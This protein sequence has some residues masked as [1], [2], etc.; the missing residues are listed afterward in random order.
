[1]DIQKL[2]LNNTKERYKLELE[3]TDNEDAKQQIINIINKLDAPLENKIDKFNN[4]IDEAET[5]SMKKKFYRLK[6]LQKRNVLINYFIDKKYTKEQA[7]KYT[8]KILKMIS[9]ETIKNANI[10]Y[11]IDTTKVTNINS[12]SIIDDDVKYIKVTKSRNKKQ[13]DNKNDSDDEQED[14]TIEE[15]PIKKSV[16]SNKK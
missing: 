12:I 3:Y 4:K 15:K 2:I 13:P 7:E 16:K 6:P 5:L 14:D 11:D 9:D 1:M 10:E 8:T